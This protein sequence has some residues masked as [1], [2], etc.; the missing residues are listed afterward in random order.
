MSQ[1]LHDPLTDRLIE[2]FRL[3]MYF[4]GAQDVTLKITGEGHLWLMASFVARNDT[5]TL[6]MLLHYS[7]GRYYI[8]SAYWATYRTPRPFDVPSPEIV[9]S[10]L[11]KVF[12]GDGRNNWEISTPANLEAFLVSYAKL[13][14]YYG[15]DQPLAKLQ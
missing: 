4:C 15:K 3:L 14:K 11:G 5:P 13:E 10:D 1:N 7:N 9:L 2:K 8:E 12:Y 6:T